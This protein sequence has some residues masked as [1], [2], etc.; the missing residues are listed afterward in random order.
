[1]SEALAKVYEILGRSYDSGNWDDAER[2]NEHQ[3]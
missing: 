3:P 2:H 1:M